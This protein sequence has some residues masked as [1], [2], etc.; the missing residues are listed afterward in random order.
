MLDLTDKIKRSLF[1]A[2]VVLILLY[3]CTTWTLTKGME[4]NIDGNYTRM[5]R[6]K[7]NKSWGNNPQ[8]SSHAATYHENS[9]R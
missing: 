4:K 6:A 2:V 7:L 3:E 8:N 5:L 1:Q 9:L